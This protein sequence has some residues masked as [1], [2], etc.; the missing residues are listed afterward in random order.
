MYGEDCW[1]KFKVETAGGESVREGICKFIEIVIT[2]R[3]SECTYVAM[4][5]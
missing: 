4:T 1:L 3:P 5:H 2:L